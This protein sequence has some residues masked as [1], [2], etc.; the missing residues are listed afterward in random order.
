MPLDGRGLRAGETLDTDICIVGAGAAG[1]VLAAEL[2]K[3]G[4]RVLLIEA[5]KRRGGGP[6]Q[7]LYEGEV[8]D[9]E[10]HLPPDRDRFRGLGGSSGAWGGRCM[11]FD[12][13][14]FTPRP[15]I[16]S[17][18]WPIGAADLA[19]WY[20]KAQAYVD[21]GRYAYTADQAGLDGDLIGGLKSD[22]VRTDTLERWSPPTHFGKALAPELDAMP[23]VTVLTGLV[24]TGVT[25]QPGARPVYEVQLTTLP[26]L[27]QVQVTAKAIVLS[28]GGLETTRI[29][30]Q[31]AS[32]DQPAVGD[33]S[34]WL[35]RGY[36]CHVMGTI[37]RIRLAPD[38]RVIFGFEKDAD[39]VF[40]RR[41]LTL[42]AETLRAHE[43]P[44]MYTLL[45]RPLMNDANHGSALLSLAYLVKRVLKP[46][47]RGGYSGQD[48]ALF[49][50]VRNLFFGA[51]QALSVLPKLGRERFL[52][53]R[54]LPSL[55]EAGEDNTYYL[56]FHAEQTPSK[57]SRITLADTRDMT[58]MRRLR[59]EPHQ[60]EKDIDGIV[61]A[62]QLIGAELERA[63]VG[64]LEFLSDDPVALVKGSNFTLGH[65]IGTT[66]MSADPSTGVVDENLKVHGTEN[67]FI[68]SASVFPT[69]SQAHP[70]LTILAL[71]IR[72][73]H[74]LKEVAPRSA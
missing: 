20:R 42:S 25:R 73:A 33:H 39:G 51:P 60:T 40:I 28:G 59:V 70:T 64:T 1:M 12:P 10:R 54:R 57:D 47:S 74:H 26:K 13:V 8:T 17:P 68:A 43:L 44:N 9:T 27:R 37:A 61:R 58:G 65:H 67:L 66:R 24:A 29:L 50:H 32:G 5:G 52:S 38:T 16:D 15:E 48:S 49:A 18:G 56:T 36:M 71:A 21:C 45:D 7:K 23:N 62:H 34:G 72:L 53:G 19:P 31:S 3:M 30:L 22:I 6:S 69:S 4:Y 14:D 2:G 63:G 35:G 41:R 11:P 46:Q 55:L